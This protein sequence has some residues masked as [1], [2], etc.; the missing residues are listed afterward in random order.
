MLIRT[1]IFICA[2]LLAAGCTS[3]KVIVPP[4][5]LPPQASLLP[6]QSET[7]LARETEAAVQESI[8]GALRNRGF[9]L[10]RGGSEG[11]AQ[12]Q[13]EI[14]SFSRTSGL[15]GHVNT[16]GGVLT[17]RDSNSQVLVK[18]RHSEVERGGL[19]FNSG[20]VLKGLKSEV[21]NLGKDNFEQ[22]IDR[23]AD[24][25]ARSLP[26]PTK[27]TVE[28]LGERPEIKQ[29]SL[30]KVDQQFQVC[31]EGSPM[32]SAR[33]R[34]ST[35]ELPLGELS[36]GGRYCALLPDYV[37]AVEVAAGTV[38]ITSP[39]G[40]S[41]R[42]PITTSLQATACDVQALQGTLSKGALM[43][44]PLCSARSANCGSAQSC[45]AERY[46]L[47]QIDPSGAFAVIGEFQAGED[48]VSVSASPSGEFRAFRVPSSGFPAPIK[49]SVLSES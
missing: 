37:D 13:V 9:L 28:Q 22:W 19:L 33:V 3:S 44:V 20:Q 47:Y 38:E 30:Q 5:P 45:A 46:R 1:L 7:P 43:V 8:A 17:V 11:G 42:S 31:A 34:A 49:F 10:S 48:D 32:M 14:D 2:A 41:A 40:L 26:R 16:I 6:L 23:F 29:A 35:L 21:S 39:F 15:I 18:T 12:I 4:K 27:S 25:L 36:E 24:G